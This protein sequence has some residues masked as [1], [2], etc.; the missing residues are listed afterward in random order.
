MKLFTECDATVDCNNVTYLER[1]ANSVRFDMSLLLWL[2]ASPLLARYFGLPLQAHNIPYFTAYRLQQSGRPGRFTR[3]DL[4]RMARSAS[5][6][7]GRQVG[8]GFIKFNSK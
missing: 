3:M 6:L 4:Q 1:V 2:F 7:Y 5:A 8:S